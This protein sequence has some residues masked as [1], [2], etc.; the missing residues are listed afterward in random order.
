MCLIKSKIILKQHGHKIT[1]KIYN[2]IKII[3]NFTN[4]I[5]TSLHGCLHDLNK[6]PSVPKM[7]LHR[8]RKK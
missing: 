8:S 2:Q 1:I 3:V 5:N 4:L 7:F 6:L